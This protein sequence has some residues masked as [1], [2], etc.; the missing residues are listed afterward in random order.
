MRNDRREPSMA[1]GPALRIG[2]LMHSVNP[3]GGVVHTLELAH[4]LHARGNQINVMAIAHP[5]QA[6]FRRVVHE[7]EAVAL[8]TQAADLE[9]MVRARIDAYLRHLSFQGRAH[10]YDI[11]HAQ[12]GIGANALA[13]LTE[14]GVI[15]GYAAT[16]HHIDQWPSSAVNALQRRAIRQ[17][18]MLFCVS[19]LW[20]RHLQ[21]EYGL[22]ADL[23]CNGVDTARFNPLP[24]AEDRAVTQRLGLRPGAPL[25]IS[26]GGIEPRKNTQ[27]LLQ[28]F[29]LLRTTHPQAQWAIVGG[30]SLLDHSAYQAQFQQLLARSGLSV[31]PGRD[32][33]PTGVLADIEVP[34]LLRVA[35][36]VA[37]P[38]LHEGFGLVVIEAL[39]CGTPVVA[40]RVEPFTGYLNDTDVVWADPAEPH[41]IATALCRAVRSPHRT[42]VPDVCRAFSWEHSATLHLKRYRRWLSRERAAPASLSPS[43]PVPLREQPIHP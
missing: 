16:V 36:V 41:S 4:A 13:T 29:Q 37:F 20:Q 28:A 7:F 39:A 38:S 18:G 15:D 8:S 43:A 34:A 22:E 3:R 42:T 6:L 25:V 26:I 14:R 21:R 23:V 12:D 9:H 33:I 17:A 11:L 27:R 2:F 10:R 5:Q 31:G 40:S 32:V 35:D 24:C 30:A 19:P 1:E